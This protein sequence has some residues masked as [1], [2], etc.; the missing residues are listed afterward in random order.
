M[1]VLRNAANGGARTDRKRT[2]QGTRAT[3]YVRSL[4]PGGCRERQN[5][6]IERL[7]TLQSRGTIDGF[8]IHVWGAGVPIDGPMAATDVGRETLRRVARYERWADEAGVSLAIRT[9]ETTSTI[10]GEC[11]RELRFPM[12]TLAEVRG[13][14]LRCVTPHGEGSRTRTVADRL[15]ALERREY[16]IEETADP[17]G[18]AVS[19]VGGV[20]E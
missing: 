19:I 10:T 17:A 1:G 3:L 7:G 20:G 13:G 9:N 8:D 16:V 4:S 11:F 12:M 14:D 2:G 15:R 5:A 6:V 18:R